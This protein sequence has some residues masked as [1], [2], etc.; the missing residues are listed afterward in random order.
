MRLAEIDTPESRQPFGRR[1]KESLASLCLGT[2][3]SLRPLNLDRYGRTV[4][5]V[6][7]LNRDAS[8][9][10]VRSGMAWA[11][12]RYLTDPE[13]ARLEAA[14]RAAGAGLWRDA[15]PVPP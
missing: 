13:I 2:W 10:Q 3:A 8:F 11:F 14:A 15:A 12:L 1:S 7:C 4:A 9:E 5:R 6:A